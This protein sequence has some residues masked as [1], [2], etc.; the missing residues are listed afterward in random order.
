MQLLKKETIFVVCGLSS[1]NKGILSYFSSKSFWASYVVSASSVTALP[2]DKEIEAITEAS[3]Y[4]MVF[5]PDI[6][7]G[8][9]GCPRNRVID[10]MGLKDRHPRSSVFYVDRGCS[11][12]FGLQNI[13]LGNQKALR[14]TFEGGTVLAVQNVSKLVK[15]GNK[16]K[17]GF[18]PKAILSPDYSSSKIDATSLAS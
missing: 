8:L 10:L 5:P 3:G 18:V 16:H 4:G 6:K 7:T 17:E 11:V 12:H 13:E 14:V 9:S 1:S 15:M 2:D